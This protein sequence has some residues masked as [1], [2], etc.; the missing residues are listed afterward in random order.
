MS[1][2]NVQNIRELIRVILS[3]TVLQGEPVQVANWTLI[4]NTIIGIALVI[5]GSALEFEFSESGISYKQS[6]KSQF[7]IKAFKKTKNSERLDSKN[8]KC[9]RGYPCGASCIEKSDRCLVNSTKAKFAAKKLIQLAQLQHTQPQTTETSSTASKHDSEVLS[10]LVRGKKYCS[11]GTETL[12]LKRMAK[13]Y[14][15]SKED[16]QKAT[17][18]LSEMSIRYNETNDETLKQKIS[19]D[20]DGYI[21]SH[22]NPA[23]EQKIK[24]E[25]EY[26]NA[27]TP[28]MAGIRQ[29]LLDNPEA[30][31]RAK[32]Q[33]KQIRF[34]IWDREIREE[35]KQEVE[36]V[37]VLQDSQSTSIKKI[38]ID[39]LTSRPYC[40][41]SMGYINIGSAGYK[42]RRQSKDMKDWCTGQVYHEVSHS[43]E[44]RNPKLRNL[45]EK[46]RKARAT[47]PVQSLRDITGN[48]GY[49]PSERAVPDDFMSPYVG[50]IYPPQVG[51]TEVISMGY[52]YMVSPKKMSQ[53]FMEDPEHFYLIVGISKR[54][55]KEASI[56]SRNKR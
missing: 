36:D 56:R 46:W 35:V 34:N 47:G 25:S 49:D 8:R 26:S 5:D 24:A 14:R 39:P 33:L 37:L 4:D 27:L 20:F 18:V 40:Y 17:D 19:N 54:N 44:N 42:V 29:K 11:N 41:E 23:W 2:L 31:E 13:R 38:E 55:Q 6:N 7:F 9:H 21:E 16:L 43:F 32:Q 10:V 22:Y 12:E 45:A 1:N 53:L 3:Q 15:G 30:R 48:N 51:G 50:K 28:A 52:E